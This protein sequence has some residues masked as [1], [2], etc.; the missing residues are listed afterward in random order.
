MSIANFINQQDKKL[1]DTI[2]SIKKECISTY[3]HAA[4]TKLTCKQNVRKILKE[5]HPY[6]YFNKIRKMAFHNLCTH[7]NPPKNL[8]ATLGLGLRFCTQSKKLKPIKITTDRL[9]RDLQ[10]KLFFAHEVEN[11]ANN[12]YIPSLYIPSPEWLPPILNERINE[13]VDEFH[14]KLEQ[15]RKTMPK[16]KHSNL[17]KIQQKSLLQLKDN[18]DFIIIS[19]DKNLGPA[20]LERTEYI[21]RALKE[22]LNDY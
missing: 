13:M 8:R 12:T 18:D 4:D 9:R 15:K 16:N 11:E 6:C 5:M 2:I 17:S 22:H 7:R 21:K 10:V 20:I 14:N 1:K 19:C 3:Q